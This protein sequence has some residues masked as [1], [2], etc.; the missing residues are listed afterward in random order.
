[1]FDLDNIKI[2]APYI[3]PY[4]G[5]VPQLIDVVHGHRANLG[6]YFLSF[7]A[8]SQEIQDKLDNQMAIL[9]EKLTNIKIIFPRLKTPHDFENALK[10]RSSRDDF[11]EHLYMEIDTSLTILF[12]TLSDYFTRER[13]NLQYQFKRHP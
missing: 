13:F 3:V 4:T 11:F 5:A 12:V 9:Y 7:K 1:M 6:S 10:V 2:P 8:Y